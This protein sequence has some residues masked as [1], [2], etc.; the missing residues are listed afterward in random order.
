[1]ARP[2]KQALFDRYGP[3]P[4]RAQQIEFL[5]HELKG[6]DAGGRSVLSAQNEDEALQRYITDFMRP[7][8]GHE[9][10]SDIERGRA[11]LGTTPGTQG[12]MF[13]GP[14]VTGTQMDAKRSVEQHAE[15]NQDAEAGE[16]MDHAHAILASDA[17]GDQDYVGYHGN[18]LA[19]ALGTSITP[20]EAPDYARAV[21]AK[22][23]DTE[24]GRGVVGPTTRDLPEGWQ[25]FGSHTGT[26]DIPREQMPQIK[27]EHRGAMVNFLNARGISHEEV[28]L[29][30][31]ALKPS[32][33]EFS[34][35]KVQAAKDYT[36][37]DRALL[38]DEKN[39]VVDGYTTSTSRRTIAGRA[40]ALSGSM[41]R[42]RRSRPSSRTCRAPR[43]RLQDGP[44][45]CRPRQSPRD[46]L[47]RFQ[48]DLHR[49]RGRSRGQGAA[50]LH[51]AADK[52]R[53]TIRD[54][55]KTQLNSGFD[56]ELLSA[57]MQLAGF[58]IEAGARKFADCRARSPTTSAS[59]SS[60]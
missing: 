33:T 59:S 44:R 1:V 4:T 6:G 53:A 54:K 9:T 60:S 16:L 37:G 2:R 7:A 19:S 36:G 24:H 29:P 3:N 39:H 45:S 43:R 49:R 18:G 28:T 41:R 20:Q 31:H 42:S 21:L 30:A 57:G 17:A 58:H 14:E 52:A 51:A 40:S 23:G 8:K 22:Y 5:A 32:Q 13:G 26:L 34:P 11:A 38:I 15:A 27:A 12:D 46:R 55:L 50:R 48:Q 10:D 25:A 56:P 47:R 35:E